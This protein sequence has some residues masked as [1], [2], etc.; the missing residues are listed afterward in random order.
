[1]GVNHR[2][3]P[4][5]WRVLNVLNS[6]ELFY[7]R[8]VRLG[9][10]HALRAE[11]LKTPSGGQ[12]FR[13]TVYG[14][15]SYVLTRDARFRINPFVEYRDVTGERDAGVLFQLCVGCGLRK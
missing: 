13:G 10:T 6:V 4:G 12:P 7:N 14:M 2:A 8:R 9:V 15:L 1:M 5:T 3:G 11:D